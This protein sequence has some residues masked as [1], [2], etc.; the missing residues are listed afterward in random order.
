MDQHQPQSPDGEKNQ[1]QR[2]ESDVQKL[3]RRHMSDPDH[4]ISDEEMQNVRVGMSPPPDEPTQ[5]AINEANDRIADRKADDEDDTLPGAQ[6]M[7][8][9]D[10]TT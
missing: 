6:K 2:F 8:P 7:T 9:W 1:H 5:Q 4:V 10:L 3:M